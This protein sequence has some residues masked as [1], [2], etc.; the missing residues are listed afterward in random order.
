MIVVRE[1]KRLPFFVLEKAVFD[2]SLGPNSSMSEVSG[3]TI[4]QSWNKPVKDL[5]CVEKKPVI[6]LVLGKIDSGKSSCC[7]FLL[8]QLVSQKHQVA[9]LDGDVGQSDIGPSGTIGYALTS[10][11]VIELQNLKLENAFFV[12]VTS[13]IKAIAKINE[14]L[15]AMME[16]IS[17][18][19]F[20]FLIVNTDGWVAGD[21]AIEYK[22]MIVKLIKPDFIIG[23]KVENELEPLMVTLGQAQTPII[24]LEASSCASE[25][26]ADKRKILR[27]RTY[28]KYLQ[29]A[30]LQCYPMSHVTVELR[31]SVLPSHI[32]HENG[33]LVGL[34]GQKSKF[35]GIGVLRAINQT[36]KVLK[37]QTA[38]SVKPQKLV[39]GKIIINE[40]LQEQDQA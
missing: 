23:I 29:N 5:L 7:T 26:T 38:V 13:P 27:D 10:K 37:V 32:E 18:R 2:L 40:K 24:L 15:A 35:L 4:P 11:P 12:G 20:D 22:T 1:G 36:R 19:S 28:S 21:L 16:E 31:S 25:R 3:N 17:H 34:Y 30:K 33:I 8:N 14:G 9:I 6:I 39:V